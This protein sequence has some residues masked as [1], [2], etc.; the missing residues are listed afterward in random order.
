MRLAAAGF[1]IIYPAVEG[2]PRRSGI[3]APRL[4]IPALLGPGAGFEIEL[5]ERL[6]GAEDGVRA[7]LLK[8]EL[9]PEQ[10]AA[11]LDG[12]ASAQCVPLAPTAEW[13]E[14]VADGFAHRTIAVASPAVLAP[15]AWDLAVRV[16][17]GPAERQP[18]CV[19]TYSAPPEAPRPI[20]IVHFSDIHI[21][22]HPRREGGLVPAMHRIVAAINRAAPDLAVL[23]GD[24]VEN[25]GDEEWTDRAREL[26]LA[27]QA[28][29]L[30]V[31]G[32]HDYSH[33]PKVLKSDIPAGG[34]WHF[35]RR[36]HGLR[37]TSL[38][39]GGWEFIG[40]DTGPS[41][42]SLRVMTRGVGGDTLQWVNEQMDRVR[43]AG[44]GAIVYGHAPTRTGPLRSAS[45][46][47][48]GQFGRMWYG[49]VQLEDALLVAADRGTRVLSLTGHT[50]WQEVHLLR[51]ATR[52]PNDRWERM[53]D[54][55]F[56]C[57]PL[58]VTTGAA[59]IAVPA[60]TRVTFPMLKKGSHS[61]FSI[62][63]LVSPSAPPIVRF[64]LF[65]GKGEPLKCAQ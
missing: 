24:L 22:K 57:K 61:G 16:G 21:G 64:Q 20:K 4:G 19:F 30:I 53:P 35:A 31:P 12:L 3:V 39:F 38:A 43:T 1:D 42:F 13:R 5:L 32:N 37:R 18:R 47:V 9:P 51:P 45:P 34:W 8:P 52:D 58:V 10:L 49:A 48:R 41:V 17:S 63:E 56:A 36:F 2:T 65:D 46:A 11:C 40:L 62:I 28:P 54:G 33:Y 7:A 26:L 15:G 55:E 60:A 14:L 44:R 23:T 59:L 27:V 50:H 6:G 25:G 29:L